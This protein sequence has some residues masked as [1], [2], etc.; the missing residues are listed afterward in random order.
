MDEARK[1]RKA[2]AAMFS[3]IAPYYDFLN[4]FLSFGQAGHWRTK[5]IRG[6]DLKDKELFLD[7]C[8]GSGDIALGILKTRLDFK[9]NA[10]GIDFSA[11]MLNLARSRVAKLG[12][13]YPRR[14]EFMMGDALDLQYMDEKF[15]M[16]SVGY[17]VRNF[18]DTSAG[19]R[20]MYRVLK[21]GGQLNV[22]EFFK[23]SIALPPVQWFV[24]TVTPWV[25]NMITRTDAFSYLRESSNEFYTVEDFC[26]L[27]GQ[28][29]FIEIEKERMTFGIAH[30][31]RARK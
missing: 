14:A 18:E 5:L 16:V 12:A 3:S 19:L 25:G 6:A 8:T 30:I 15:D 13:P 21:F 20:E 10:I 28:V 23:G 31:I 2:I 9:G 7:V 26:K 24:D 27:L 29:G 11:P 4:Q 22:I 17:G 1:N